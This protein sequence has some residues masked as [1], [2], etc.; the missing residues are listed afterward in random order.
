MQPGFICSRCGVQDTI[1][2]YESPLTS[3]FLE[4][5]DPPLGSEEYIFRQMLERANFEQ[6]LGLV[7]S[8]IAEAQEILEALRCRRTR[9]IESSVAAKG[10]LSPVRR[11]PAEIIGEIV[12]FALADSSGIIPPISLDMEEGVWAYSQV[13]RLWR[14]EIL[15]R[16]LIWSNINVVDTKN[17]VGKPNIIPI[18][19]T[20]L[21][22]SRLHP[23]RLSL[24]L[25]LDWHGAEDTLE[26]VVR[27]SA[28]WQIVR[29]RLSPRLFSRLGELKPQVPLLESIDFRHFS[30]HRISSESLVD[31]FPYGAPALHKVSFYAFES[32]QN[33]NLPWSKI[34]H[35]SEYYTKGISTELLHKTTKLTSL[36]LT[37]PWNS[38]ES[39]FRFDH[40]QILDVSKESVDI[41]L[42]ARLPNLRELKVHI[43]ILEEMSTVIRQSPLLTRISIHHA[44]W[45]GSGEREAIFE[46]FLREIPLLSTLDL[47]SFHGIFPQLLSIFVDP[48]LTPQLRHLLLPGH[49]LIQSLESLTDL[50]KARQGLEEIY[51]T[52]YVPHLRSEGELRDNLAHIETM[53]SSG[54]K[55]LIDSKVPDSQ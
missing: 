10:V 28:S 23:L 31:C 11:I 1:G 34:T 43:G 4:T 19:N 9:I 40:L 32:I 36:V 38:S 25:K 55:V 8:K 17:G 12:L 3:P 26:A 51:F 7:E 48:T 27:T 15:S 21:S 45:Q 35:L 18:L 24:A 46:S 39:R 42:N 53:R 52:H 14:K 33:I 44:A 22:R 29:L 54:L 13:C 6:E 37:S 30:H 49:L 2:A 50:V 5:N 16:V 20:I 41:L 47:S